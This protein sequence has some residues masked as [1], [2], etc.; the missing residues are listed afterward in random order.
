MHTHLEFAVLASLLGAASTNSMPV[1]Q[2]NCREMLCEPQGLPLHREEG[3]E[4]LGPDSK[5]L[6]S[7]LPLPAV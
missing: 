1:T 4:L 3:D 5:W 7:R 6:C 2:H